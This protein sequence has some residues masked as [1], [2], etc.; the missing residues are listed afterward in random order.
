MK[1]LLLPWRL[2]SRAYGAKEEYEVVIN[3]HV[4]K[5]FTGLVDLR[6]S[7]FLAFL[8]ISPVSMPEQW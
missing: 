1:G 3:M 2:M 6:R 5:Y 8:R 7:T 4:S